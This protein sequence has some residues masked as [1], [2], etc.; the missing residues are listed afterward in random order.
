MQKS[1]S[2]KWDSEVRNL[3]LFSCLNPFPSS[4]TAVC[5]LASLPFPVNVDLTT[6]QVLSEIRYPKRERKKPVVTIWWA[7][8]IGVLHAS[9]SVRSDSDE[10]LQVFDFYLQLNLSGDQ[11]SSVVFFLPFQYCRVNELCKI[12]YYTFYQRSRS[13]YL[14]HRILAFSIL[15]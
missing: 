7:S 1:F 3:R 14:F 4:N 6:Q 2:N 8:F 9:N 5:G 13:N 11:G 15:V 10:D 12:K